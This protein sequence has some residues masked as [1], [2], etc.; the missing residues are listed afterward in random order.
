[1]T[2]KAKHWKDMTADEKFDQHTLELSEIRNRL[3]LLQMQIAQI[4][5]TL[6]EIKTKMDSNQ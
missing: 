3:S 1:M 4:E 6:N 2:I 5:N